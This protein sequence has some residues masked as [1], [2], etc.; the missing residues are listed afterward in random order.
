MLGEVCQRYSAFRNYLNLRREDGRSRR[1]L[2]NYRRFG[3]NE[4]VMVHTAAPADIS[5][6]MA[7]QDARYTGYLNEGKVPP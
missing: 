2:I 1:E 6:R 4:G 5:A 7:V 3:M